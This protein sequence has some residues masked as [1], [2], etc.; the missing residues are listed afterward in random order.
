M[1]LLAAK[2]FSSINTPLMRSTCHMLRPPQRVGGTPDAWCYCHTRNCHF[3][4]CLNPPVCHT[5]TQVLRTEERRDIEKQLQTREENNSK[6]LKSTNTF[7][8]FKW[9]WTLSAELLLTLPALICPADK[10]PP[11]VHS[12]L[13]VREG[14]CVSVS[15]RV[16]VCASPLLPKWGDKGDTESLMSSLTVRIHVSLFLP[17]NTCCSARCKIQPNTACNTH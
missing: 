5:S 10:W 2:W 4:I 7:A 12:Y 16:C 11:A 3:Q 15:V 13:R 6:L 9:V 14:A 8:L 1:C 17:A